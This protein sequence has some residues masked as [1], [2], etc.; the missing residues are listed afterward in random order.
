MFVLAWMCVFRSVP[1][2][3]SSCALTWSASLLTTPLRSPRDRPSR[4]H[5]VISRPDYT[6]RGKTSSRYTHYVC[7]YICTDTYLHAAMQ[8]MQKEGCSTQNTFTNVKTQKKNWHLH[9]KLCF[10]FCFVLGVF[11]SQGVG[12]PICCEAQRI[13]SPMSIWLTRSHADT[14]EAGWLIES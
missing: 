13:P 1:T 5:E 3:W 2:C 10:V 4:R 12:L 8:I 9:F 6:C 11:L 7:T 14:N